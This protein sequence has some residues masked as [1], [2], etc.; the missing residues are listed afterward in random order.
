MYKIIIAFLIS[1]TVYIN[2]FF[3]F[4]NPLLIETNI[5]K[6][7]NLYKYCSQL[8]KDSYYIK[9]HIS[10]KK[11]DTQVN[12]LN[13]NNTLYICF[14][15]TSSLQDWKINLDSRLIEYKKNNNKFKIHNGFYTQYNSVKNNIMPFIMKN[16]TYNNIVICGHSLGGALATICSFDLCD[17]IYNSNITCVTFGS[18]RVGDK[19]FV[20]LYNNYNISTHRIVIS[21]DPVP[22]WP[23]NGN[24]IHICSCIY[25]KDKKIYIKPNKA[26]ISIKRFLIYILNFDHNL[27]SHNINNYISILDN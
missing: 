3:Q 18:P 13:N 6:H 26:Y 20:N 15:G 8:S 25:F 9:P 4:T 11:Y 21:G 16:N 12:I 14:R 23:L 7:R 10:N 17:N 1:Y 27:Y 5:N 24:Y 19:K 2:A 22:K